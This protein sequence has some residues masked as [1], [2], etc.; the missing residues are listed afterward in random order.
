MSRRDDRVSLA[1]AYLKTTRAKVHLDSLRDGI[2][3]FL[4]SKPITIR[5]EDDVKRQV[6]RVRIILADPP[7]EIALIAG[8]LFYC[9]RSS[10]DQAIWALAKIRMGFGYPTHT[11]FPI[12][13]HDTARNRAKFKQY[14]AGIPAVAKSII[15]SLQPYHRANPSAHR[16]SLLNSMCN[17]DKHRRIAV[18][19]QEL[20]FWFPDAGP[21]LL[22]VATF[23]QKQQ[24]ISVPLA[25]KS[26]MRFE[27]E[28]SFKV[29]FGDYAMGVSSDYEAIKSV[30]HFVTN[31]VLP[32]FARF[33]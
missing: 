26:Q 27:P 15:K 1:D 10:L 12:F 4:E 13:D 30:Y 14:T 2:N 17:I 6:Y 29:I 3:A 7:V 8:D 18:H 19:G 31:D 22:A 32:R 28:V 24:M 33:F 9:L 5:R 16:L 20:T 21:E 25:Y 23:D 11:Q